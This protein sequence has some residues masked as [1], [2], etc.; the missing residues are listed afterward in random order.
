[1][2]WSAEVRRP[3]RAPWLALVLI[4]AGCGFELRGAAGL[5]E[6]LAR[7]YVTGLD[8][9]STLAREL[10]LG[11][12]ASGAE[13]VS[14][15]EEASAVLRIERV[16]F[17]RREISIAID[18]TVLEYELSLEVDFEARGRGNDLL[19]ARQGVVSERVLRFEP[20]SVLSKLNEERRLR[21]AMERD[22]AQDILDRLRIADAGS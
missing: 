19:I 16:E 18:A 22:V 15:E 7:T 4:L 8:R 12:S 14:S 20:A 2:W 11:L 6:E 10:D 1:M 21:D 3:G 5:P 13:L 9:R 17:K